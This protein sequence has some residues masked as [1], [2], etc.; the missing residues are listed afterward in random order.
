MIPARVFE[1]GPFYCSIMFS[2]STEYYD[3][4]CLGFKDYEAEC[5]LIEKM[6]REHAAEAKSIL[7][8]ACGTGEHARI[9]TENFGYKVDGLD[10]EEGFVEIARS[11]CPGGKFVQGDMTGFNLG[12]EY[13]VVTC[14]FS[15]IGYAKTVK[16]TEEAI[17]C[18]KNHLK[19]DGVMLVEPWIE[20]R[21]FGDGGLYLRTV[22][23]PAFKGA[24]T[25]RSEVFGKISRITFDYLIV[26]EDE[27]IRETEVHELGLLTR[28][29]LLGCFER[30]GLI[31]EYDEEGLMDRGLV[32]A[33]HSI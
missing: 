5:E 14:L 16:K 30:N 13:D 21:R 20:P 11:K 9:L 32:I 12:R 31:V 6:I 7:D 27:T 4:I 8:I 10:Y 18:F 15:A 33:K 24:R 28:E 17:S 19:R 1:S 23:E 22:D 3:R 26:T 29:E 2:K 25:G